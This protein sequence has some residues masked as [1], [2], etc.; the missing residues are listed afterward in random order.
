MGH[1]NLLVTRTYRRQKPECSRSSREASAA[2]LRSRTDSGT[3][4]AGV[5]LERKESGDEVR[6]LVDAAP[7]A[8]AGVGVSP[9]RA[10]GQGRASELQRRLN[11]YP[12]ARDPNPPIA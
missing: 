2:R 3:V 1:K 7:P 9:R 4:S 11:S 6:V 10:D 12:A 8:I 5:I